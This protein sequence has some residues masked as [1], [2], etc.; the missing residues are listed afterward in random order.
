[1]A[2]ATSKSSMPPSTSAARS[3]APTWSAPASRAAG[4]PRRW[5]TRRRGRPCRCPTGSATV[6]RTIWSALRGSTPRRTASSTVSSNLAVA[7]LFTSRAPR[8]GV[9]LVAVEALRRVGVLLAFAMVAPSG[10]GRGPGRGGPGGRPG[11]VLP[12]AAAVPV[13]RP[14]GRVAGLRLD[15]DAHG[16][17]GAGDLE[18]GGVEVV[19]VE[20]GHLDLGDLGDLGVGDRAGR[21]LAGVWRPCRR[22]RPGGAAPGWAAS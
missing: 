8:P 1:V 16:A 7:R 22:R 14:A 19:G 21:L 9:Q 11:E 18:L 10:I 4:R 6:P 12:G 5:R 13:A 2:M 15:G 20:V 3:S 17:G